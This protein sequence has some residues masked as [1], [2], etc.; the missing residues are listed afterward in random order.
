MNVFPFV[1][2]MN[3]EEKTQEGVMTLLVVS[4]PEASTLT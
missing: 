2:Q 4:P 3:E 1:R